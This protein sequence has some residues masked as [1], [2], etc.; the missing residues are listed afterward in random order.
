MYTLLIPSALY[1]EKLHPYLLRHE[2]FIL[3]IFFMWFILKMQNLCEFYV[4]YLFMTCF[5]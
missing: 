1:G 3:G 4:V 2:L 5:A